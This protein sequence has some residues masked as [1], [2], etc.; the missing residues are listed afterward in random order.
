MTETWKVRAS[1]PTRHRKITDEIDSSVKRA[2]ET[3]PKVLYVLKRFPQLSQ[4]FVVREMLE[5]ERLGVQLGVDALAPF[6]DGPMHNDVLGVAAAVRY[7]PRRPKLADSAALRAHLRVGA[8]RP[9]TWLKLAMRARHGDWRRFVQAGLVADRVRKDGYDHLHAH[10]ASAASEVAR[11]AATLAG[12]GY[13]VTA[14]AKDIF[15]AKHAPHLHQR[16]GDADAVVTVSAFNERHLKTVLPQTSIVH[17]SNAVQIEPARPQPESG[18]ILCVARM[19]EK[20]GIDTL[21]RALAIRCDVDPT[22]RAEIIGGGELLGTLTE[23]RD[24]LG[25]QNRV[26]FLG[27]Q[28]HDEVDAAYRRCS[29]MVLPCRID[30]AGDRDGLPTVIVEAF[31]HAVPVI[32]TAIIGIPEVVRHGVTGLLVEPDDPMGLA[33]AIAVLVNDPQ[34]ASA[35]GANGRDMVAKDFDPRCSAVRLAAVFASSVTAVR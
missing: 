11:D 22:L 17:I 18:P 4:T 26:A 9:I 13:S 12:C 8:R 35:L 27:P 25:L 20:K 14:H 3:F 10:F 30:E 28:T 16:L 15:H 7:L 24:E 32:S 5:L 23:L 33:D 34:R 1:N 6:D 19:V 21:L 31:A 29:M 2:T